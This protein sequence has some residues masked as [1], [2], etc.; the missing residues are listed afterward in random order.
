MAKK[1]I[2]L[3]CALVMLASMVTI[4]ATVATAESTTVNLLASENMDKWTVTRGGSGLQTI[5]GAVDLTGYSGWTDKDIQGVLSVHT[6][7]AGT[8]LPNMW[9]KFTYATISP[10]S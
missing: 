10:S 6:F 2:S 8:N 5:A 1:L 7:V 9:A 4:V 3:L